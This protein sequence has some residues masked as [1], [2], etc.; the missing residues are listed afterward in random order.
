MTRSPPLLEHRLT[1]V[2]DTDRAPLG[3]VRHERRKQIGELGVPTVLP[4]QPLHV[5]SLAPP[6]GFADNRENRDT[7][8]G[9][10]VCAIAG[11]DM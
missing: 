2:I 7:D 6:A 5:A 4:R 3:A 1:P 11:H 10:E 9:P 8:I